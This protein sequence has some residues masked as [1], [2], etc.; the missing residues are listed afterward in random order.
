MDHGLR[1]ERRRRRA[2]ARHIVRLRRDFLHELRAHIL[3]GVLKLDVAG[4]G[5]AVIRNRRRAELL[6]EHHIAALGAQRDLHRVR[7]R[8]HA[9]LQRAARFLTKQNLLC[10]IV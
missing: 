7:Q 2:V 10:H 5:D 6:V 4:D 8:V 3:K 1:E 9:A